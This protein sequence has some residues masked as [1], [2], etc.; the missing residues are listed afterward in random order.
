[1]NKK[2][3][4]R[5]LLAEITAKQAEFKGKEMPQDVGTWIDEKATEALALQEQIEAEAKTEEKIGRLRSFAASPAGEPASPE[6][7]QP[8]AKGDV[9]GYVELGEFVAASAELKSFVE[10]GMPRNNTRIVHL[11][12]PLYGMKGRN[13][14]IPLSRDQVAQIKAVPTLGANVIEPVLLPEV[15]RVTE[16][17]R[18][19]LRD[20]LNISRTSRD[21]VRYTRITSYTRA[22]A[23]VAPSAQKPQSTLEMDAVTEAVRKVA[24][25]M[26][27]E[28]EQLSDY[29]QLSGIIND[30]LLFDVAKAVEE[31]VMWGDGTGEE[32]NG[33]LDGT[34]IPLFNRAEGGDTL[35]DIARRMITDIRLDNYD[36]TGFAVHPLDWEQIVL[37][38]GSDNRYIWLVVTENNVQRLHG[39]PVAETTAVE[40][41]EGD[42]TE[43]RYMVCGDFRRGATLWDREDASISVGF[44]NDQFIRNQRTILAEWRGAFGIRRPNAFSKHRTQAAVG[45]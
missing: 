40:A 15:V 6:T 7:T 27:V 30:E 17:D 19:T 4:H 13:R 10:A 18:L 9:A 32:F 31:L 22:A 41:N 33:L 35:I 42:E 1:M 23:P 26:P 20:L 21:A 8:G 12:R 16:H 5:K 14:L 3:A 2:E 36:P 45:S 29:P 24:V 43:E 25:W 38:K 34:N 11:A 28:D 44:I 39:L 37:E